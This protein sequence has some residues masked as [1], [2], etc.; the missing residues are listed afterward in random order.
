MEQ[1]KIIENLKKYYA[2]RAWVNRR[3]KISVKEISC[4]IVGS[5]YHIRYRDKFFNP[6]KDGFM[7]KMAEIASEI[8]FDEN[9][10]FQENE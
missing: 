6:S 9:G 5:E 4:E 10:Y 3:E 2:F 8:K 7:E 1:E